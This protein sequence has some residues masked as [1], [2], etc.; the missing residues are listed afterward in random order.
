[1]S[2]ETLSKYLL[3]TLLILLVSLSRLILLCTSFS[4]E[5]SIVSNIQKKHHFCRFMSR[6]KEIQIN[7]L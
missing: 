6:L 2:D 5:A 3:H 1:M 4:L 7:F